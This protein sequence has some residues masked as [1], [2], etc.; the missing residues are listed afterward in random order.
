M[1]SEICDK[2]LINSEKAS[3]L[4]VSTYVGCTVRNDGYILSLAV[5]CWRDLMLSIA[6]QLV[7]EP[8]FYFRTML[9]F[10]IYL[11]YIFMTYFDFSGE[12]FIKALTK[13]VCKLYDSSWLQDDT[14]HLKTG[15]RCWLFHLYNFSSSSN[16]IPNRKQWTP[17][18][19]KDT[20]SVK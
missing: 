5:H 1:D 19:N 4:L 12:L 18:M 17:Y 8:S 6:L 20:T 11:S 13:Q 3:F 7:A 14:I 2:M 15:R 16:F 9:I 10:H